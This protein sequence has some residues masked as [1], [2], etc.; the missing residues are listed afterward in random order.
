MRVLRHPEVPQ[1]LEA[2]AL[3]YEQ[4]QPG[5]GADFLEAYQATL[6]QILSEPERW[7]RI[8]GGNRNLNFHIFPYAVVYSVH[9]LL[10]KQDG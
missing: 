9:G 4:R 2:A 7:R 1:E 5:L 10:I 6:A 3:W 8:R